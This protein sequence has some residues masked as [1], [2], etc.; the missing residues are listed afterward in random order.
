M[1]LSGHLKIA[2]LAERA[3]QRRRER[4]LLRDMRRPVSDYLKDE[5]KARH[6][7]TVF[8]ATLPT[9]TLI[10]VHKAAVQFHE[11]QQKTTP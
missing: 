2:G 8:L 10:A 6:R 3:E 11:Q 4:Y 7:A 1:G 5:Q 9:K